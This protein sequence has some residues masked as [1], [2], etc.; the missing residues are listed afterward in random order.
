MREQKLVWAVWLA[1][2]LTAAP[3]AARADLCDGIFRAQSCD[4]AACDEAKACRGRVLEEWTRDRCMKDPAE[5]Q[6]QIHAACDECN[7]VCLKWIDGE[8][9]GTGNQPNTKSQWSIRLIANSLAQ[10]YTIQYPSL[11]CGGRWTQTS[12]TLTSAS[13]NEQ[14]TYGADK[15]VNSGSVTLR[16]LSPTQVQFDYAGGDATA[17]GTLTKK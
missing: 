9:N 16:K 10:S 3:R 11:K 4:K 15:C 13:F 7:K 2:A 12:L 14:I 5:A 1:C 17:S 8:W 6:G